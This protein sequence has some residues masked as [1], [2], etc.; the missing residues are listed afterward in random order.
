MTRIVAAVAIAF[1][2]SGILRADN[3]ASSIRVDAF[4]VERPAKG[5]EVY[6]HGGDDGYGTNSIVVER[7]DGLLVVDAQPDVAT[8][9]ALLAAIAKRHRTPVRYLVLTHPHTDAVGGAAAFP[10]SVL[11]IASRACRDALADES[12][13]PSAERR[14][15]GSARAPGD[16]APRARPVLLL[17][18]PVTLEDPVMPV[19]IV[20]L[21]PA[22]SPGDLLVILP[23]SGLVAVGDLV[24]ADGSP[25]AGDA[26]INRWIGVLNEIAST[27]DRRFLPLRGP[28][29]DVLS[30]RRQRESLAW[31]V[32]QIDAAFV[33]LVPPT[34]IVDR[35]LASP[36]LGR[37]FDAETRPS[38]VRGVVAQAL[39]EALDYR[40]RWGLD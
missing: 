31:V 5:V 29:A 38:V 1:A 27:P 16:E 15:R 11:K 20:P 3:A 10:P 17:E 6:R 12:F 21:P 2:V 30:V 7:T 4:D 32:G 9:R 39:Q 35:V 13:D 22:H 40:R 25:Y 34:E 19:E 14:E 18:A 33:D 8:A 28:A 24:W 23:D 26:T 37:F 36:E